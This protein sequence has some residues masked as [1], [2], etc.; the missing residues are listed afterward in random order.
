[1]E[2]KPISAYGLIGN[3]ETCPLVGRD[4][5]IDWCCFPHLES[6]SAFAALLDAENGGRFAIAPTDAFDSHQEYVHRTNVLRTTFETDG[7]TATLTDF[8]PVVSEVSLPPTIVRRVECTE[9]GVEIDATFAPRFDYARAETT[10]EP[11]AE[12]VCATGNDER[13]LLT[14]PAEFRVEATDAGET[15]RASCS[16]TEGETAW[17]VLQYG[18][19]EPLDRSECAH[20]LTDTIEYWREWE[21]RCTHPSRCPFDGPWHELV[22]RSE[23]VFKLLAH[24]ETNAIAAAPTTSLPE[25]IGGGRNWDYRFSWI[26]DAG[27]TVRSLYRLGHSAE[28]TGYLRWCLRLSHADDPGELKQPLYRPLYGLHGDT[29]LEE[30]TLDHL[31]GYRNSR[32]VRIG[33]DARAQRQH[34]IYGELV[35]AIYETSRHGRDLS[36]ESWEAIRAV[37]DHVCTIWDEPDMGIWE[38]RSDPQHF[39]HSKILCWV[40]LDR[41][42]EMAENTGY[43]ADIETWAD[44]RTALEAEVVDRGFDDERGSF[45]QSYGNDA[46]DASVLRIPAVGFLPPDDDRVLGTIDAVIDRLATDDG[47]VYRYDGEDGVAGPD[48]PFVLCSFWLV[49]AL[50][51]A[52][53][54]EE[55]RERFEAVLSYASP[56]GLLSEEID[57]ET[58]ALLGNFPQAFSHLGLVDSALLL[59]ESEQGAALDPPSETAEGYTD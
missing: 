38:V 14:G 8:M 55:A 3:L 4:G 46:L 49:D 2:Y 40:A 48:N 18:G 59:A 15:A 35:L 1:M 54:V 29:E 36:A 28:A 53:R 7:G 6:S 57:P 39:V 56:L 31:S 27:L 13:L 32:P 30:Q 50:A 44:H 16:L 5:S 43:D 26:R 45:T 24:H 37:V 33:N 34:D 10:L 47:L 19:Y 17:F 58:G 41:G 52:G 9:G 23:L 12:G 42:I 20:L 22:V 51:M 25:H 11:V 21:H